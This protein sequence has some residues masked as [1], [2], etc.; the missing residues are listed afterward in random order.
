M[1]FL[2]DDPSGNI[3]FE[4]DLD[5]HIEETSKLFLKT[6]FNDTEIEKILVSPC[7]SDYVNR[8]MP[9]W[10]QNAIAAKFELKKNIDYLVEN[11]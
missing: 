2:I 11:G 7:R 6:K 4:K 8:M 10:T 9:I 5:I 3:A 1:D